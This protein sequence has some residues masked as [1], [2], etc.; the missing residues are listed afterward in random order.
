[1]KVHEW[2]GV[3]AALGRPRALDRA[4]ERFP[5]R[6][7]WLARGLAA[8]DDGRR[9]VVLAVARA[10]EAAGQRDVAAVLDLALADPATIDPTAVRKAARK[11]GLD[12][13]SGVGF[14][15]L[16]R[17]FAVYRTGTTSPPAAA[18]RKASR[19]ALC[20][21]A[22]I[23]TFTSSSDRVYRYDALEAVLPRAAQVATAAQALR[24]GLRIDRAWTATRF[25]PPLLDL[26]RER[27]PDLDVASGGRAAI[28]R[29]LA[30]TELWHQGHDAASEW[31]YQRPPAEARAWLGPLVRGIG[32]QL[33]AGRAGGLRGAVH[34]AA[35]LA[36]KQP[37][38][39]DL[40]VQLCSLEARLE[41]LAGSPTVLLEQLWSLRARLAATEVLELARLLLTVEGIEDERISAEITAAVL[42]HPSTTTPKL[43]DLIERCDLERRTLEAALAGWAPSPA[44]KDLVLALH[45]VGDGD[46]S[47][48][49]LAVPRLVAAGDLEGVEAVVFLAVDRSD[50]LQER[51]LAAA[52][53]ALAAAAGPCVVA[54]ARLASA[55]RDRA[56]LADAARRWAPTIGPEPAQRGALLALAS[57]SGAADVVAAVVLE[58]GRRLRALASSDADQRAFLVLAAALDLRNAAID[59]PLHDAVAALDRFVLRNGEAAALS[60]IQRVPAEHPHAGGLVAWFLRHQTE[61]GRSDAWR[62]WLVSRMLPM[63]PVGNTMRAVFEHTARELAREVLGR[64]PR[65]CDELA[66][67]LS[68]VVQGMKF[69]DSD[70]PF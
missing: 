68:D 36:H 55:V 51:P 41:W 24:R 30:G 62:F 38:L 25:S 21:E 3:D 64:R 32:E 31:L 35:H 18:L 40:A 34:A 4:V 27:W 12:V 54:L 50:R 67:G 49:L 44:R 10:A 16:L 23:D 9:E 28:E 70:L 29:R 46:S 39:A 13:G 11:A 45:A 63:P 47:A 22:A 37:D 48:A 1:M 7:A 59:D 56:P 65:S 43:V 14:L 66:A 42:A 19:G 61:L 53:A 8:L 17:S 26:D 6:F 5:P 58:E 15:D 69:E 20:V 2:A 52:V 33:R 57:A 60:A